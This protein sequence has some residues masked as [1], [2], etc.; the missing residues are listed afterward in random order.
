MRKMLLGLLASPLLL[1]ST[2][3]EAYPRVHKNVQATRV[4]Y[5]S[6]S[7]PSQATYSWE[8]TELSAGADTVLHL[9][10]SGSEVAFDDDGGVGAA[11]LMFYTNKTASTQSCTLVMR[12]YSGATQG[13]ARLLQ[14][15]ATLASNAPVG[16]NRV[17]VDLGV[18]Y[19]YETALAPNGTRDTYL[20]ALNSSQRL[21]ALDDDGGV[22]WASRISGRSDVRFVVVARHPS[23]VDGPTHLYVNDTASD[24]DGDGLGALLEAELGTCDNKTSSHCTSVF[25]PRDTDRD[26]LAD[27]MEVFGVEG[28]PPQHLPAW[29]ADPLHKDIFVEVDYHDVFASNPVT[30]ADAQQAQAYFNSGSAGDLRNPNGQPG[31][32][33]HLDI[34]TNPTD[35]SLATLFGNWG[36]SGPVP[37]AIDYRNAPNTYRAS[38]R[39]GIFH[40]GLAGQGNGGGQGYKPG[41]RFGWGAQVYNRYM[42]TFAHEL[43]HNLNLG[44]DGHS[45]WGPINCKPHYKSLMNYAA[46]NTFSTG[47]ISI[48]LNPGAVRDTAG[49]GS[50]VDATYLQNGPFFRPVNSLTNPHQ[51]DWDF[52]DS[53]DG[54]MNKAPLNFASYVGCD[55]M[56]Q[57]TED[58][59]VGNLHV[60][61]PTIVRGPQNR[62]YAFYV[63]ANERIYYRQGSTDAPQYQASCPGGDSLGDKCMTWSP[64]VEVPTTANARGVTAAYY[65]GNMVLAFRTQWDSVRIIRSN[66]YFLDGTLANW[67]S[68]T[69][70]SSGYTLHEPEIVPMYVSPSHFGGNNNVLGIFYRDSGTGEYR[71]FSQVTPSDVSTYQGPVRDS[72]GVAIS[73]ALS[74]TLAPWPAFSAS[75]ASFGTNCGVFADTTGRVRFY[76]Y[77]KATNRFEDKS[78]SALPSSA[79]IIT[80]KHGVIFHI[81]RTA[82]GTPQLS[83]ATRGQFWFTAVQSS[84]NPDIWMSSTFNS[85]TGPGGLTFSTQRRGKMG[86]YW[87]T[88]EPGTGVALYE[89]ESIHAL[90]ALWVVDDNVQG[91]KVQFL[92][93]ADGAFYNW[94]EGGSDFRIMERGICLGIAGQ[95]YC[96]AE[97]TSPWNL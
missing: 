25:N 35:P 17:I 28:S 54:A 78:A 86:G 19:V 50:G 5:T 48:L 79:P 94:L 36:G 84:N 67:Q 49:L 12:A 47:E 88:L 40:Y 61:T 13:T 33:L 7:I 10:C 2:G 73:G 26:G 8:T 89:D 18:G 38:V 42:Q 92:P 60:S 56:N 81:L 80:G 96:G 57:N 46:S 45:K 74:P 44:H 9:W 15:G 34:G 72:S 95:A 55:A 27:N 70:L 85:G 3:A 77:D 52:T 91:D 82:S 69:W 93:L 37:A 11:S 62:L 68:E 6:V 59:R 29:G 39:A 83:D 71:W 20:F 75:Y 43:G 51:V 4:Y 97:S 87:T 30:G 22:G 23:A 63:G 58:L 14:N 21:V 90:K 31:V 76:C 53:W 24:A 32:R 65:K 66:G 64:E 16:G 1:A 41:D